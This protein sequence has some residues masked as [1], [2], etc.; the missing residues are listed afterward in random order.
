MN[1]ITL[2]KKIVASSAK[3][4]KLIATI[5][6]FCFI[7]TPIIAL[8]FI[9]I[10]FTLYQFSEE[11]ITGTY[12]LACLPTTI[13]SCAIFTEI[14]GGDKASS[15][16]NAVLSNFLGVLF[17]PI[18]LKTLVTQNDTS[19]DFNAIPIIIELTILIVIP[20]TLGYLAHSKFSIKTEYQFFFTPVSKFLLL[21]IVYSAFCNTFMEA[22]SISSPWDEILLLLLGMALLHAI[23]L[24]LSWGTGKYFFKNKKEAIAILFTAPQK[25]VAVGIPMCI[26]L[27]SGT[28]ATDG[29][30]FTTLPLL[31]YNSVQWIS[32]GILSAI[33]SK[34]RTTSRER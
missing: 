15:L 2:N 21:F 5:Q 17:A 8:V 12:I 26:A 1:G 34:D 32:A 11:F 33:I 16:F 22:N 27:L 25:T 29:L 28:D 10:Y 7:A 23:Y 14:A 24:S 19:L 9:K 20:I 6:S 3:K 31:L 4:T 30:G 18:I 13:A